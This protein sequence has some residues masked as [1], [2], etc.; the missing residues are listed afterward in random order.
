[1]QFTHHP[2]DFLA[3]KISRISPVAISLGMTVR[4]IPHE[5][6]NCHKKGLLKWVEQTSETWNSSCNAIPVSSRSRYLL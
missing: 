6:E 3:H 5:I 1:M 2:T 4:I